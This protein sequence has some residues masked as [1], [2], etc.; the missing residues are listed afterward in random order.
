MTC[1]GAVLTGLRAPP[2]QPSLAPSIPACHILGFFNFVLCSKFLMLVA[3]N[4]NPF[5]GVRN[6]KEG[7]SH[8]NTNIPLTVPLIRIFQLHP[9]FP[10]A[11]SGG[12]GEHQGERVD[13]WSVLTSPS[14][15]RLRE[16]GPYPRPTAWESAR[17]PRS[18]GS[19]EDTASGVTAGGR[20]GHHG[21]EPSN[22][23]RRPA[24][25]GQRG[26]SCGQRLHPSGVQTG[27]HV[28][29]GS[30]FGG[31]SPQ[32]GVLAWGQGDPPRS[33]ADSHLQVYS[34]RPRVSARLQEGN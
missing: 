15:G 29:P 23:G 27:R 33:S 30:T 4:P 20:V 28:S 26:R 32:T 9:P 10:Q 21:P 18:G 3:T 31:A 5:F 25:V 19:R 6:S 22:P 17:A 2:P 16:T 8:R 7:R 12:F 11:Q 34:Q 13:P 14:Q 1:E 24:A